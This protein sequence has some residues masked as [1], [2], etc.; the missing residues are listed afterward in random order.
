MI[1][2]H[3]HQTGKKK[4]KWNLLMPNIGEN[5]YKKVLPYNAGQSVD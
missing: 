2:F 1:L 4:K 3:K 5:V